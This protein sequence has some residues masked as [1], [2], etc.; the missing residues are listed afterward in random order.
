MVPEAGADDALQTTPR[1]ALGAGE[2]AGWGGSRGG[3]GGLSITKYTT[4]TR[5][6]RPARHHATPIPQI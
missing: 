6:P 4:P 5:P 2:V 1:E 3:P